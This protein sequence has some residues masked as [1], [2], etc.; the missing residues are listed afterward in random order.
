MRALVLACVLA[1]LAPAAARSATAA[2]QVAA[3]N[4]QR[5]SNG[6]PGGIVEQPAWSEGCRK[7]MA[8]IAANGGTLTHE[9]DPGRPGYTPDGAAIG[10]RAVITP[11]GTAFNAGGN[12]FEF[13]PLHLMQTLA[14]ALMRMGVWGGCAT[15]NLG[16]E[17]RSPRPM[18]FSYP[19][20]GATAVYTAERAMEM[21]FV[22]GDFV[23]LPQGTTTGPHLFV[24]SLGTGAGRITYATLT[25]PSGAVSVRAVDNYTRGL[26]GYMPPGGIV[27]PI[28]PL[29]AGSVYRA[30]ATFQPSSGS[31]LT[32]SWSMRTAGPT[33]PAQ[34]A[35]EQAAV[36][37][38]STVDGSGSGS[39][40]SV[41]ASKSL[42]LVRPRPKGRRLRVS[43]RAARA[44]RGR[45]AR[46]T[47]VQL[48]RRCRKGRCRD[49]RRSKVRR[50]VIRKLKS[51]QTISAPRPSRGRTLRIEVSTKTFRRSG[52]TYRG[53]STVLR[54]RQR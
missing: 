22:P 13:A 9:E 10:R 17:R 54:W 26:E 50:K 44:L 2:Q 12:A 39:S 29:A 43:L 8:Y 37:G 24:M 19:G 32:R 18:L 41:P 40:K 27:I 5:E 47:M 30:V 31:A 4:A 25:G 49:T 6:I 38:S 33:S 20:N 46:V 21:P 3:L 34:L 48:T 28:A 51:S 23:G 7:H 53:G 35:L 52:V 42:R 14:P 36:A 45:R 16:Y 11:L 1:S 15:T